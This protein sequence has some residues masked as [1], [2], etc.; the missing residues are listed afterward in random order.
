MHP[1]DFP[2]LREQSLMT[3]NDVPLQILIAHNSPDD[4]RII[5]ELLQDKYHVSAVSTGAEAID[6]CNSDSPPK[7]ILLDPSMPDVKGY[8]TC[9]LIKSNPAT[10][11]INIIF[12]S[13][14]NTDEAKLKAFD[15]GAIDYV[16]KPIDPIKFVQRVKW[17]IDTE[18]KVASASREIESAMDTA[19][20]AI[21]EAGEQ[22]TIVHFLQNTFACDSFEDLAQLVVDSTS[23]FELSNTV[24]IRTP[25][26]SVER[27]SSEQIPPI[28][29]EIFE[30]TNNRVR[31]HQQGQ[32]LFL[33]FGPISQLIKNL[34]YDEV[35]EGRLR[36]HLAIILEGAVS[37]IQNLLVSQELKELMK[38]TQVSIIRVKELQSKQKEKGLRLVDSLMSDIQTRF[39]NYGLTE[40][41]EL[42]ITSMIE[43]FAERSFAAFEEGLKI[44]DELKNIAD[45]VKQSFEHARASAKEY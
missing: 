7:L 40:E 11:D 14:N 35:K 12:V 1:P 27:S 20:A 29:L 17:A 42:V 22:A 6:V 24:Q 32:R 45:K 21:M 39:V 3:E 26:G 25:F 15:L 18:Y 4:A 34:P 28:E 38:E 43:K 33:S 36:D 2:K 19:M 10:S 44:D 9:E 41:Q 23:S 31:I 13:A 30:I 37:R 8:E 5:L 16:L